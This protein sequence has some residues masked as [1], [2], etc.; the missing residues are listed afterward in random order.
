MPRK[1]AFIAR[2]LHEGRDSLNAYL[3]FTNLE[4]AMTAKDK[5]DGQVFMS[6]H[7]RVDVAEQKQEKKRDS[8]RCVFLGN[9]GFDVSDEAVWDFFKAAGLDDIGN[10]YSLLTTLFPL[11]TFPTTLT[12]TRIRPINQRPQDKR[13]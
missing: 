10:L 1:Q 2:K 9:L 8:K 4:H 12:P 3:V 7:L 13:G 6:R 11:T 5:L